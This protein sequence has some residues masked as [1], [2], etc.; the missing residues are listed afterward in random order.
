MNIDLNGLLAPIS[1][2]H[3]CGEDLTFSNA[4]HEIKKAQTQDDPL[5]DQGDWVLPPKQ[6]DWSFVAK[7]AAELLRQQSKDIRLLAW[8]IEAWT[9][10]DGFKGMLSGLSLCHQLLAQY[11][12]EIYPRIEEED[13]DQRL[14]LLQGMIN[15]LPYLIKQIP[16]NQQHPNSTLL[17]YENLSHQRHQGLKHPDEV[18]LAQLSVSIEQAEQRMLDIPLSQR[19]HDYQQFLDILAHWQ[20][21]KQILEQCMQQDAPRFAQI[22]SMFEQIDAHLKKLYQVERWGPLTAFNH[23]T[24]TALQH[25]LHP[26]PT[27]NVLAQLSTQTSESDQ[28]QPSSPEI[29][30]VAF[31]NTASPQPHTLQLSAD[32]HQHNRE[33]AIA[34]LQQISEYFKKNEPHS[35]VSYMLEKT[36][37]WSQLPLHEWLAQVIKGEQALADVHELL[38]AHAD[39]TQTNS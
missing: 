37:L 28:T 1:T 32:N 22:D 23:T 33:H 15:Q 35:P 5:L 8:L 12:F 13:L 4:F 20:I 7:R 24:D 2:Q 34:T 11:W 9:H 29:S 30:Q 19:Q 10:L 38:G 36:I 18:D 17:A 31:A 27:L 14:G 39:I 25:T 6:A 16:L 21:L 26:S 3:P